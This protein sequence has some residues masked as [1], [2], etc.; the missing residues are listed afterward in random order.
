[1]ENPQRSFVRETIELNQKNLPSYYINK[2]FTLFSR[3]F[4][5][6]SIFLQMIFMLLNIIQTSLNYNSSV[7][8]KSFSGEFYREKI[9]YN[10]CIA[11]I[12]PKMIYNASYHVGKLHRVNTEKKYLNEN[13]CVTWAEV[14]VVAFQYCMNL[15]WFVTWIVFTSDSLFLSSKYQGSSEIDC[16]K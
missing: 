10:L 4:V 6:N 14:E 11:T 16:E 13:L 7:T 5:S 1:M 8:N 9:S 2:Y 12:F 3:Q 15:Y